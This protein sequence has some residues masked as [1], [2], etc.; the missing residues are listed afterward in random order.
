MARPQA[1]Q[2]LRHGKL[3]SKSV[4]PQFVETWNYIVERLENIK[5]DCDD[6]PTDGLIKF[7]TTDPEHP[8]IRLNKSNLPT[9]ENNKSIPSNFD[10]YTKTVDDEEKNFVR[11]GYVQQARNFYWCNETEITQS[12]Y[13]ELKISMS[14]PQTITIEQGKSAF[15][16][17]D[18]NFTYIPLWHINTEMVADFDYRNKP[19][20]QR[21][22]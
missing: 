7:D 12:G 20:M 10:Y 13:V 11:G 19:V 2:K 6:S 9:N 22:E 18:A 17:S 14:N 21:W 1:L 16:T 8:V 4:F 3:L 5:G 15:S